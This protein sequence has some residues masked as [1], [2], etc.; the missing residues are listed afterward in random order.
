YKIPVVAFTTQSGELI[1]EKPSMYLTTDVSKFMSYK[2]RINRPVAVLYDPDRP[3]KF[4]LRDEGGHSFGL[5]LTLLVG[6]FFVGLGISA[7]VGYIKLG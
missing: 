3:Q 1:S 5:I 6:L 4:I 2:D 7:L